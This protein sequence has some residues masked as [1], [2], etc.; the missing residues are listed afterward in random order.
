[1]SERSEYLMRQAFHVPAPEVVYQAISALFDIA[2][3]D[4]GASLSQLDA[5]DHGLVELVDAAFLAGEV[6]G[7]AIAATAH[8]VTATLNYEGE[9]IQL[10]DGGRQIVEAGFD[11]VVLGDSTLTLS[12]H[13]LGNLR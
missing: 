1:M 10:D 6:V 2:L 5:V 12:V 13:N 3:T 4:R 8:E 11:R 9:P 7:A